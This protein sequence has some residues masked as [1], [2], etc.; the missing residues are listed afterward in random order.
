MWCDIVQFITQL[1]GAVHIA[2]VDTQEVEQTA[3]VS[4]IPGR[5][6]SVIDLHFAS[7]VLTL[8]DEILYVGHLALNFA[9]KQQQP[10][11]HRAK[12]TLGLLLNAL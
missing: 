12:E 4:V 6:Q 11:T 3:N 5:Q 7:H 1:C 9:R 10:H 2:V 8:K